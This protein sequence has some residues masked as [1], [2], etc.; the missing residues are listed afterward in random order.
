MLLHSLGLE[1]QV[2]Q[3]TIQQMM[4]E[5]HCLRGP[6][7]GTLITVCMVLRTREHGLTKTKT[8][9]LTCMVGYHMRQSVHAGSQGHPHACSACS[10]K[11]GGTLSDRHGQCMSLEPCDRR[12]PDVLGAG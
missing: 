3:R 9:S 5:A 10:S 6:R 2:M 11:G 4:A 1:P 8:R 7:N 12:E